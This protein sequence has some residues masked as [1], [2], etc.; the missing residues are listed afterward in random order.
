MESLAQ[1]IARRRKERGLRLKDISER[2]KKSDGSS[3][4]VQYVDDLEKGR[5]FPTPELLSQLAEALDLPTDLLYF[6]LGLLPPDVQAMATTPEQILSALQ[7]FRQAL[8]SLGK[9][10]GSAET[11]PVRYERVASL[12]SPLVVVREGRSGLLERREEQ[13]R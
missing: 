6:V 12:D 11:M 2:V 9:E 10:L 5:R 1:L 7:A 8:A 13:D 4:S 3:V